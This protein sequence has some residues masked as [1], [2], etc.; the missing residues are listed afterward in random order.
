MYYAGRGFYFSGLEIGTLEDAHQDGV[1]G[2]GRVQKYSCMD[3]TVTMK[4]RTRSADS[5]RNSV[6]PLNITLC[7]SQLCTIRS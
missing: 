2:S 5:S 6:F 1:Q 4:V 7:C 3:T